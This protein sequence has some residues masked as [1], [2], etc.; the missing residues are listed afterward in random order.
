MRPRLKLLKVTAL[1]SSHFLYIFLLSL[2]STV[3]LHFPTK[4]PFASIF[5]SILLLVLLS[6]PLISPPSSFLLFFTSLP[7]PP[8]SPLF[9]FTSLIFF[10]SSSVE[11]GG[12]CPALEGAEEGMVCTRFPPEPSGYLHIGTYT[13]TCFTSSYIIIIP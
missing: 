3:P 4:F 7:L 13:R 5:S 2:L 8:L 10:S 1:F 12:T 11:E 9:L 6:I